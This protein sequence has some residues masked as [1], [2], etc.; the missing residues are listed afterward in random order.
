MTDKKNELTL[1]NPI[2]R[3]AAALILGIAAMLLLYKYEQSILLDRSGGR[4][5]GVLVARAEIA[6]GERIEAEKVEVQEIPIA[7]VH[8]NAVRVEDQASVMRQKVFRKIP[9]NSFLQWSDLDAHGSETTRE[10]AL[11]RGMRGVPL[12]LGSAFG[13]SRALRRGDSIDILINFELPDAGSLTLTLFQQVLVLD[14]EEGSAIVALT[15]EQAEQL[16]FAL[17]HGTPAIALRGRE[18]PEQRV[19]PHVTFSNLIKG[20]V[21]PPKDPTKVNPTTGQLPAIPWL[22]PPNLPFKGKKSKP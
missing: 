10:S 3:F 22:V 18:D 14:Q 5:V 19:L 6:S 16:V 8:A 17:A 21:P 1:T 11:P 9:Q 4:R 20:Y 13:K 2:W 12:P 15:P 7:Y